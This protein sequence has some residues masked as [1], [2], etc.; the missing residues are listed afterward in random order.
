MWRDDRDN[1]ARVLRSHFRSVTRTS[2]P[3]HQQHVLNLITPCITDEENTKLLELPSE[4]EVKQVV[5]MMKPWAAPG[6]DGFQAGF[7]QQLWPTVGDSIVSMVQYF[8]KSKHILQEMNYTYQVLI[9]KIDAPTQPADFRPISLCNISYKIISKLLANRLKPLLDKIISPTQ[10]AYVPGRHI[11]DNLII[12]H[13]LVHSMKK[14]K[15]TKRWVGIKLDMSKAF[16]RI[17]WNFLKAVLHQLGFHADWIQL[18]DQCI[19][20]ATIS[21]L[22]NGTPG[23]AFTQPRGLQQGDPLSPYLSILCME[24][25]SRMSNNAE[26]QGRIHGIKAARS[27][28]SITYLCFADDILLF[29]KRKPTDLRYLQSLLDQF[30]KASGQVVNLQKSAVFF[31]KHLPR[32]MRNQYAQILQMKTIGLGEKYLGLLSLSLALGYMIVLI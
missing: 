32:P 28:P 6:N 7:Y 14:T 25:F 31:N 26:K 21:I 16:G 29:L 19:S 22:L 24:A 30:S 17:E 27:C 18:I 1:I 9:P 13:E 11:Q 10:A 2:H 12:A 4:D 20:T 15:D 8:F 3:P 23:K 5:F